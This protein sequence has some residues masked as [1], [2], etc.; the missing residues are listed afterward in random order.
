MQG[1]VE[2]I[3]NSLEKLEIEGVKV[4]IIHFGTGNITEQDIFLA[5]ASKAI[6]IGFNARPEEGARRLADNEGVDV[7]VYSVIYELVEDI[8]KALGG[9]IAGELVDDISWKNH[10]TAVMGVIVGDHNGY[11]ISGGSPAADPGMVSIGSLTAA[12]AIITAADNLDPGDVILIELHAPGPHYDFEPN[13]FQRVSCRYTS[14][15]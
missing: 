12:E 1:S 4:R 15:I 6:V 2:P 8:E 11:G 3:K 9:H 13:P 10:G 5:V 14:P 7:R